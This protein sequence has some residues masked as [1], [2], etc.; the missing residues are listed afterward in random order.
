[1]GVV[2]IQ[3]GLINA[4]FS[5]NNLNI[6]SLVAKLSS[7]VVVFGP[8]LASKSPNLINEYGA[9][10]KFLKKKPNCREIINSIQSNIVSLYHD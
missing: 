10:F 8:I 3:I 5:D 2:Q 1:M 7:S 4:S 9:N 6:M